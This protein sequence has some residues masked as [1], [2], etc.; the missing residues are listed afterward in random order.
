[1]IN[2]I[3]KYSKRYLAELI[4]FTEQGWLFKD[5]ISNNNSTV[6]FRQNTFPPYINSAKFEAQGTAMEGT[7]WLP[8]W[9]HG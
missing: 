7:T 5:L 4:Y 1:M 9:H 6:S 8:R 2:Q 3:C